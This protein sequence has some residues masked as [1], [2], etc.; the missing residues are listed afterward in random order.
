MTST[1][2]D[3]VHTAVVEDCR[4][5]ELRLPISAPS[6]LPPLFH[7]YPL[8]SHLTAVWG[9]NPGNFFLKFWTCSTVLLNFCDVN[10]HMLLAVFS[11][12]YT[13][14]RIHVLCEET[15]TVKN[16]LIRLNLVYQ[17]MPAYT[18]VNPCPGP[19]ETSP[20]CISLLWSSSCTSTTT[21]VGTK[22]FKCCICGVLRP[23]LANANNL[24]YA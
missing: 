19:Y 16:Y 23:L 10:S 15:F 20:C 14:T 7:T 12:S 6:P 8:L 17:H 21:S 18:N 1:V 22:I 2:L 13:V 5:S 4:W 11:W 9:V 24:Y 3:C